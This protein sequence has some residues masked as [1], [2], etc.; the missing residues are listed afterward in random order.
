LSGQSFQQGK[1]VYER[2]REKDGKERRER[3]TKEREKGR[4][5][6][7]NEEKSLAARTFW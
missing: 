2:E 3:Q 6:G 1:N 7:T 5:E 4:M